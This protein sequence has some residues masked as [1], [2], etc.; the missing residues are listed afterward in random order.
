MSTIPSD[1]GFLVPSWRGLLWVEWWDSTIHEALATHKHS[2]AQK[3]NDAP[4]F[5]GCCPP[6]NPAAV[7]R[8]RSRLSGSLTGSHGTPER[9]PP[10]VSPLAL[11]DPLLVDPP[12]LGREQRMPCMSGIPSCVAMHVLTCCKRAH[13]V[14]YIHGIHALRLCAVLYT[15]P[16]TALV[17]CFLCSA[18]I[19]WQ[20]SATAL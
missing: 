5:C 18:S 15:T 1:S 7:A 3:A 17:S 13:H 9:P 4:V 12:A 10:A 14:L 19:K 16:L 6:K 20:P 2:H 8:S 11:Q